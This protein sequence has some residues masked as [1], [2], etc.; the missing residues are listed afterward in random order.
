MS[1]VSLRLA[2]SWENERGD[3]LDPQV[4]A[5][6]REV[7][8]R[9]TLKAACDR[10]GLS[11][12]Y[13]WGLLDEAT[14]F[15]NA[16]LVEMA[17]GRGA[18]LT[19]LGERLLDA[20]ARIGERLRPEL[21]SLAAACEHDFNVA[22]VEKGGGFKIHASHDF[23][24]S[25]LPEWLGS[26]S[27]GELQFRG[28]LESLMALSE[29]RCDAAGFHLPEGTGGQAVADV[30]RP[31]LRPRRHALLHLARRRQGL[32]VAREN[33]KNIRAL[34]DLARPGVRF[35]N[36][37][38]GSGTRLILDG[39][40]RHLGIAPEAITGYRTE[41]FTHFAVAAAVA[42]GAAD[43]TFGLEAAAD[44][45]HLAFI[46]VTDE[47][48]YL[49]ARRDAF[50]RPFLCALQEALKGPAFQALARA[51][52]GYDIALAGQIVSVDEAGLR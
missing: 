33:L 8:E 47:R 5:L 40:L 22:I 20:S 25:R 12:R 28:S 50:E 48:Y 7:R 31:W 43:A 13:A 45:F 39:L 44:Q 4:L 1:R 24:L 9:G 46:P 27:A 10:V 34:G 6:L 49:A 23:L 21:G 18:R 36:R 11:Y 42:S 3:S 15:L 26:E 30:Y 17:R 29:K 16:P 41:E 14:R 2:W 35:V 38:A 32:I 52:P 51:L 37:Q 19:P